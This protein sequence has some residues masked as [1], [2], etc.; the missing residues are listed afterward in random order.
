MNFIQQVNADFKKILEKT[1]AP[2]QL[3]MLTKQMKEKGMDMHGNAFPTFCKPY[4]VDMEDRYYVANVTTLMAMSLEKIGRAFMKERKFKDIIEL[5]KDPRLFDLVKINPGYP[6]MQM[7]NRYDLFFDLKTKNLKFLE[8]NCGDPSGMGWNDDMVDIFWNMPFMKEMAKKYTLSLDRLLDS[9]H[10]ALK[11]K[12]FQFCLNKGINP[13]T[14]PN[15][16]LV[17]WKDSTI[18]GD[19]NAIVNYYRQHGYNCWQADPADF[20]YDG[21]KLTLNGKTIDIIYRDAITDVTKDEFWPNCQALVKAYRDNNVC[22]ANPVWAATGDWKALL[23]IMTDPK[24]EKFF[25]PEERAAHKKHIPWTRLLS[26]RKTTYN[27][28][29]IDLVPFVSKNKNKIVLKHNSGYGGFGVFLGWKTEQ[30]KW[31]SMIQEALSK[32]PTCA[33]QEKVAIPMEEFPV[34]TKGK[35]AGWDEMYVNINFWVHDGEF[36]GSFCRAAGGQLVNVHQGGGLVP[37]FFVGK[38]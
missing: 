6:S 16:S 9:H 35:L 10:K 15:I 5:E 32:G 2:K 33:V 21:K 31:D 30:A 4:F 22:M 14:R 1:N 37:V 29:T 20:Q 8:F 13:Q 11:R 38:K 18:L 23:E 25:T 26:Q 19:F 12:Y 17:C 34:V 3:E 27:G 36:V 24:H 28:K 7:V